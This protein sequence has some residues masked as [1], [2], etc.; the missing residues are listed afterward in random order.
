MKEHLEAL[1]ETQELWDS[2]QK[3]SD[4]D[5]KWKAFGEARHWE[6]L[7][8]KEQRFG[9]ISNYLKLETRMMCQ[10]NRPLPWASQ[11]PFGTWRPDRS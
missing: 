7:S 11:P 8:P 4:F 10:G 2:W 3:P 6:E 9:G 5:F 1:G